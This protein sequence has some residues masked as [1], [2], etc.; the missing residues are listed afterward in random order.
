[1]LVFAA[2][3]ID[4]ERSKRIR[5]ELDLTKKAF[6]SVLLINSDV[7]DD[8]FKLNIFGRIVECVVNSV[9]FHDKERILEEFL[10]EHEEYFVGSYPRE[11]ADLVN[12]GM[13]RLHKLEM[14]PGTFVYDIAYRRDIDCRVGSGERRMKLCEDLWHCVDKKINSILSEYYSWVFD[15]NHVTAATRKKEESRVPLLNERCLSVLSKLHSPFAFVEKIDCC[16][17]ISDIC[18]SSAG[19]TAAGGTASFCP[20]HKLYV[21][22]HHCL[23]EVT[24]VCFRGDAVLEDKVDTETNSCGLG[25]TEVSGKVH[26][27]SVSEEFVALAWVDKVRI[28]PHRFKVGDN[29]SR[30]T[31]GLY[32]DSGS[33]SETESEPEF[34]YAL[35]DYISCMKTTSDRTLLCG[36]VKGVAFISPDSSIPVRRPLQVENDPVVC[37]NELEIGRCSSRN[38]IFASSNGI[39]KLWDLRQKDSVLLLPR[40]RNIDRLVALESSSRYD[41]LARVSECGDMDYLELFDLRY[42]PGED[43]LSRKDTKRAKYTHPHPSQSQSQTRNAKHAEGYIQGRDGGCHHLLKKFFR[44]SVDHGKRGHT[45]S[46]SFTSTNFLVLA[47]QHAV[48]VMNFVKAIEQPRE[49]VFD[50]L[51]YDS[52]REFHKVQCS[53]DC[54]TLFLLSSP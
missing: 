32:Y 8:Y 7:M 35:G 14:R 54:E 40:G 12:F 18:L 49:E 9:P 34:V 44:P 11:F 48:G 33:E 29:S 27:I 13:G 38:F 20:S 46:C 17:H 23:D 37:V 10:V 21:A 5:Q 24:T 42:L 16:S 15:N 47:F 28:L 25:T 43:S 22:H 41:I 50:V 51:L 26:A 1:M 3:D 39:V 52:S 53:R 4:D 45:V 36:T 2:A 31:S 19:G 6:D 30:R